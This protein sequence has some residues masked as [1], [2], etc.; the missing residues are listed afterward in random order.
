MTLIHAHVAG[1]A[2]ALFGLTALAA[3]RRARCD[4]AGRAVLA[5]GSVRSALAAEVMP[6]H[7]ARDSFALAGADDIDVLHVVEQVPRR[8]VAPAVKCR[9]FLQANFA[10]MPLGAD[11]GLGGMADQRERAE[12]RLESPKPSCTAL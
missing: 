3:P 7:D 12:L 9:R 5:F 8:P 1:H 11:A 10:E 2:D 6:L 4:R